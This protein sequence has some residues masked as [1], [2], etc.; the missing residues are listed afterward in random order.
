[1]GELGTGAAMTMKGGTTRAPELVRECA[2][3][4]KTYRPVRIRSINCFTVGMK[5]FE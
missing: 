5:P 2:V 1:M 4:R 3:E